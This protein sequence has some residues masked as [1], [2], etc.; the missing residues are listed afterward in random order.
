MFEVVQCFESNSPKHTCRPVAHS[1]GASVSVY[2]TNEN[3]I[4]LE[5]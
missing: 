2:V 4:E 3:G 1:D 5:Y